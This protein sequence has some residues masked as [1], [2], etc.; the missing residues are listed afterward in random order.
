MSDSE[1][2]EAAAYRANP[3][4]SL[5][6]ALAATRTA[7]ESG[8]RDIVVLDMT[9][10]S[11][12][13]DYFVV[14]TGTSTRHLRALADDIDHKLKVELNDRR[15]NLDGPDD[16]RWIVLDYG[17]SVVHLFDEETRQFYSLEALWADAPRLDLTQTLADAARG[18]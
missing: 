4:R 9:K 10:I 5:Q 11:A 3:E 2:Q 13:F 7:A 12:L 8:G 15:M 1:R 6:L 14:I 16:S 18:V 17:T